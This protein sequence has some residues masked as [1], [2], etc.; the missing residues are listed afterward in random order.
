VPFFFLPCFSICISKVLQSL[1]QNP[2]SLYIL[3]GQFLPGL[4]RWHC[5]SLAPPGWTSAL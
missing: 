4:F 2:C 5:A 3:I 1:L